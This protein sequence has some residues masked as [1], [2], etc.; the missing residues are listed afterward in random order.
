[1]LWSYSFTA[2]RS[3]PIPIRPTWCSRLFSGTKLLLHSPNA[4]APPEINEKST[5]KKS[6]WG[7]AFFQRPTSSAELK[8]NGEEILRP[9]RSTASGKPRAKKDGIPFI[10]PCLLTGISSRSCQG[11][12]IGDAQRGLPKAFQE[13]VEQEIRSLRI[14]PDLW[15]RNFKLNSP[16][17]IIMLLPH[18]HAALNSPSYIAI[19][20]GRD[21]LT[22]LIT[23]VYNDNIRRREQL[24]LK[25]KTYCRRR[26]DFSLPDFLSPTLEL[27]VLH[28]Q[29]FL[30]ATEELAIWNEEEKRHEHYAPDPAAGLRLCQLP[31]PGKL[32]PSFK[33]RDDLRQKSHRFNIFLLVLNA[34]FKFDC[35]ME[36]SSERFP[37]GRHPWDNLPAESKILFN[38]TL[39]LK[40][41][42][43]WKER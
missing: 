36:L 32:F 35:F 43:L 7:D 19:T 29:H 23:M 21:S 40:E 22:N 25:R 42:I 37:G 4:S 8:D 17:N 26:L 15:N 13:G 18:I 33:R 12:H 41:Q 9:D 20:G 28:P 10:E 38:L 24:I 27:V 31:H 11:A 1:M 14:I 16:S 5:Q 2:L 6:S 3:R 34:A 30:S 39:K